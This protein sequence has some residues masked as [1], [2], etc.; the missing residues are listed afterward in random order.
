MA[1]AG[2][3]A[4]RELQLVRNGKIRWM[5]YR[6]NL[7][8]RVTAVMFSER[9]SLLSITTPR[10][11]ALGDEVTVASE[12]EKSERGEVRAGKKISSILPGLSFRW[13]LF[14]QLW[15]SHRQAEIRV[16]T[17]VSDGEKERK[18]WVSSA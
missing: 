15:M 14:I 17:C 10:F 2:R 1:D 5:L 6:K 7:H 11:L 4:S 3:P 18:S 12:M 13:W 8:V 9:D 16:E